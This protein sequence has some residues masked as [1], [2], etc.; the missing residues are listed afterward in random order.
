M[1]AYSATLN[2][3]GETALTTVYGGSILPDP[4]LFLVK[5]FFECQ[6][7]LRRVEGTAVPS[8]LHTQA[9]DTDPSR[10]IRVQEGY[11]N[12]A[13]AL[14]VSSHFFALPFPLKHRVFSSQAVF[15]FPNRDH[16]HS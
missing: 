10:T 15:P 5:I 9:T 2:A 11:S 8:G 4:T 14:V 16:F 3:A 13:S 7:C 1:E 12:F 6:T